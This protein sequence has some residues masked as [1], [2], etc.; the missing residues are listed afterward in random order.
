MKKSPIAAACISLAALMAAT[1][2][3]QAHAYLVEASLPPSAHMRAAPTK[4]QLRF[5]GR[6]DAHYSSVQLRDQTGALIAA[7]TQPT[8]SPEMTLATPALKPGRYHVSYR[9]LSTDG[10]LVTGEVKFVVE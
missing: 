9:V 7:A 2:T 5:A 1:F 8:P 10:D 3:A 6:A 4:V